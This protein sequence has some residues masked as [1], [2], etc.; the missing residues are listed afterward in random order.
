L[1]QDAEE[2][3][4]K[5][6]E[7][8]PMNNDATRFPLY[9]PPGR[10]RTPW[11]RRDKPRFV[12]RSIF[13]VRKTLENELRLLGASKVILSTNVELRQDGEPYSNRRAP[14]DPGV[15]VY[16]VR[17]GRELAIAC[18]RWNTVEENIRAISDAV[19][20]IRLIERRGTGEMV[21]A[22]FQGF[23]QLPAA[24]TTYRHWTKVF[25]LSPETD[26]DFVRDTY[27]D[28]ARDNHPDR[29]GDTNKAAEINAAWAEFK[30]ERG[31]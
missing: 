18:D 6:E 2:E 14:D 7:A 29:G 15:A 3:E 31:L 27:R 30:K 21:D 12:A 26:T 13:S 22:A 25:G 19:N 24:M 23:A 10:P 5:E 28:L 20:A 11:N 17:K 8:P 1:R 9:W 4:A 16:F